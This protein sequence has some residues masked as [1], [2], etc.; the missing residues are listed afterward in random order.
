[1]LNNEEGCIRYLMKEMDPSEEVE[2]ERE[3]MK[4]ENLL[5]EVES[6]RKS[7]QKLGKLPLKEPPKELSQSV[8]DQAV[9]FQKAQIARSQLW[10]SYMPRSVAA[11]AVV[12]M[13]I[14]T[15]VYFT[16]ESDSPSTNN[17]TTLSNTATITNSNS[18]EPW[19][20]RNNTI[21]FAG[22]SAQANNDQGLQQEVS[23]SFEKLR[24]VNAETGFSA[25]ARK[26][27]LTSSQR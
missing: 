14:S 8:T 26:I 21:H 15:G 13:I 12:L 25:P 22:T 2:F 5:I 27:L 1:M 6:L 23:Q 4:D 19:V 9:K 7:Y 20:D 11:A 24:L 16:S 17:S 3:M 18:I 10:K